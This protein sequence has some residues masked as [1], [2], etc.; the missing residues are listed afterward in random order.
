[1]KTS[2]FIGRFQPFH[3]G[4]S[5]IVDGLLKEGK[6]VTIGL[7]DTPLSEKDPYSILERRDF[8]RA[9][10][11]DETKVAIMQFPDIEE[12]V[13]GR[14]VGYDIREVRLSPELEAISATQI[15]HDN[16]DNREQRSG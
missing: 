15:R 2:L 1:M 3:A 9:V 10:Y 14:D 5:A 7:R 12:V 13:Y 8:I 6:H 16:L 4:H 11:P